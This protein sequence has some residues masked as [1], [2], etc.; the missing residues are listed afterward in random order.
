MSNQSNY[1]R[2]LNKKKYEANNCCLPGPQGDRGP[3]GLE[4]SQGLI[5]NTGPRGYIGFQGNTGPAGIQGTTGS[6]GIKGDTGP[7]GSGGGG[8]GGG[9]NSDEL[10]YYFFKKPW[11]PVYDTS[12]SYNVVDLSYNY[13]IFDASSGKYDPVDQ[14]I[15]LNWK[16]PPRKAAGLNFVVVPH[17]LNDGAATNLSNSG[18]PHPSQKINDASL[19]YLPYHENMCID[20]R[21]FTPP[22]T[23]SSWNTLTTTE[24]GLPGALPKPNLYAQTRG[25]YFK[26]GPVTTLPTGKY[27]PTGTFGNANYIPVFVYENE[28]K[29]QL[30]GNQ[31]Q[32]RVYLKNKSEEI[33][34]SPD[35]YGTTNPEWNYLYLPDNSGSYFAFGSFGPATSPQ[36]INNSSSLYKTLNISGSNNNPNSSAPVA[37][38]S[39]N[40]SFPSL[41]LYNLHVNYGFDLSGSIAPSSKQFTPLIPPAPYDSFDISNIYITNNLTSNSWSFSNMAPVDISLNILN[42]NNK[43]IFPGYSYDVSGYYMKINT[44]LSY[45]VY[46]DNYSLSDTNEI[47]QAPTRA[48]V[49]QDYL[50]MLGQGTQTT[51]YNNT[52]LSSG[53]QSGQ[54]GTFHSAYPRLSSTLYTN[55]FFIGPTSQY[56]ISDP[57]IKY[58]LV[59]KRDTNELNSLGND[60]IGQDLTTYKLESTSHSNTLQTSASVGFLGQ[61]SEVNPSNQWWAISRSD[62]IDATKLP[63]SQTVEGYRLRGWYLGV[64]ISNIEIKNINLTNYPD[65][66]NNTPAYADWKTKLTQIFAGTESNKSVEYDI[67]MGKYPL[68]PVSISNFTRN[69]PSV[70]LVQDFFGLYRPQGTGTNVTTW[71]VTADFSDM[72]PTWRPVLDEWLLNGNLY[73][74]NTN[75]TMTG[76]NILTGGNYG[77]EWP[78][79]HPTTLAASEP[80]DLK[81]NILQSTYKYSRDRAFTPQFYITGE[82]RNNVTFTPTTTNLSP[83]DISFNNLPLWWDFTILNSGGFPS[84]LPFSY[85]LHAPGTGAFPINYGSGGYLPTYIHANS[86]SDS[87][88]MWC[89]KGFTCGNYTTNSN[90]NP[91]IDYMETTNKYYGQTENYLPFDNTGITKNLSYT[92]ANDDYYNGGTISITGTYKW[93]MISDIRSSSTS[94]GKIVVNGETGSAMTLGDDYLVYIQEI[95]IF[96]DPSNNTIPSGYA[97][98]RSGWKAL[99]GKWDSGAAVNIN[100]GNEAGCYRRTTPAGINAVYNIKYYSPNSNK[101]VFY[102]IGLKNGDNKKISDIEI[103]YGTT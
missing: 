80:V 3:Q 73:Y 84:N 68:N 37:D 24:L 54:I 99:H 17:Q 34:P 11:P 14:R 32:F 6:Q 95:D 75:N 63:G 16:L 48:Q 44:D 83:L 18:A 43:I 39:L 12:G 91:Y 10:N 71:T 77:E 102:R 101:T 96:F 85:T 30:G 13:G 31:F 100:N 33:L 20:Y 70:S 58:K 65:I 88:L 26:P 41:P 72:D 69:N 29:F 19:N 57:S 40:T 67:R 78:N 47:V 35:Y 93:I 7:A 1:S 60:L 103:S 56:V 66:S 59:N 2:Y 76:G 46:C 53:Y 82:Y 21:T 42:N 87:Q 92:T 79:T 55:I 38:A 50:Y 81:M 86:I 94:F 52:H 9:G 22:S 97:S 74:N 90:K 25:V 62:T 45:N 4:G 23:I 51:F 8:G 28:N 64:D 36:L 89:D 98:G 27:G 61:S 5:G 49:S 15:E